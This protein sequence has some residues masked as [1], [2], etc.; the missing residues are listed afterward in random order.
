MKSLITKKKNMTHLTH[1]NKGLVGT[2][3]KKYEISV[4]EALPLY[5]LP[6][7]YKVIIRKLGLAKM[8]GK[9]ARYRLGKYG[10]RKEVIEAVISRPCIYG[11][12]DRKLY[13]V[14]LHFAPSLL[15]HSLS[16]AFEGTPLGK[17]PMGGFWPIQEKCVACLRCWQEHGGEVIA[18]NIVNPE[19]K[20]LGDSYF[21][22]H[23]VWRTNREAT[24]GG[25]I[26]RGMGYQ[27]KF[28]G[29]ELY[30][31]ETEF[32]AI[33]TDMSEIVRPTRH[34]KLNTEYISTEVEI[35]RKP[36]HLVLNSTGQ[37]FAKEKVVKCSVP[38]LFDYL[39]PN[40]T[41]QQVKKAIAEATQEVGNF[42]V[43]SIDDFESQLY[44][45]RIIP[46]VRDE[47]FDS[48][49]ESLRNAKII[50]YLFG[51]MEGLRE[52]QK[53]NPN[54]VVSVRLP[55]TQNV[56]ETAYELVKE[57]ADAIHLFADYHG[58][59]FKTQNPR[60]IATLIRSVHERLVNEAVRDEITLIV[61]GGI[62]RSEY[63]PKCLI[64][65]AD[66]VAIDTVILQALQ[67]KFEG[68]VRYPQTSRVTFQNVEKGPIVVNGTPIMSL[69][70]ASQRLTNLV[71]SWKEQH[72]EIL[73]A[74][75]IRDVR[76]ERGETGRALFNQI[77]EEELK[78]YVSGKLDT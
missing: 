27:G 53:S 10:F 43:F 42:A 28:A 54:A 61:S 46:L 34:G 77:E 37:A 14:I 48:H 56:E 49:K 9:E 39:P 68:E 69:E 21:S 19:F 66:L 57:G 50:E 12:F 72:I 63:V 30:E 16:R 31:T 13:E 1:S 55:F 67:A 40:L 70:W 3:Y 26:T 59:E 33:W 20:K 7:K 62:K 51:N 76:R 74:K 29:S 38:I 47:D 8:L 15:R 5:P 4:R 60:Y 45:D 36:P 23:S 64:L 24:S 41:N 17:I 22:P 32:D 6:P 35:G 75:G 58:R 25:D 78:A 71:N 2:G 52:L 44:G 73:S 11:V 18:G 65:G